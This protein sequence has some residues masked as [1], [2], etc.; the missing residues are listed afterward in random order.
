M[1]TTNLQVELFKIKNK[2]SKNTFLY[3][4]NLDSFSDFDYDKLQII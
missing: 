4:L 1:Y 3:D 2:S